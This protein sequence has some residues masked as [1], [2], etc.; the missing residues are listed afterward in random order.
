MGQKSPFLIIVYPPPEEYK[1]HRIEFAKGLMER[2]YK[3]TNSQPVAVV[4]SLDFIVL[5]VEGNMGAI[6]EAMHHSRDN[7]TKYLIV[8][9]Q[10]PIASFGLATADQWIRSRQGP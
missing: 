8:Q 4:K 3:A 10:L 2:L 9:P 5:L 6:N 1:G 7:Q